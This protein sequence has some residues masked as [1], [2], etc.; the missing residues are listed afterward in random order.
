[1]V[2]DMLIFILISFKYKYKNVIDTVEIN[3]YNEQNKEN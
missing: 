1:M 2:I 3:P